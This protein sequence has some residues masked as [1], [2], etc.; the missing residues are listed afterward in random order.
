MSDVCHQ[1][2]LAEFDDAVQLRGAVAR[3]RHAGGYTRIEVYSPFPIVGM[4]EVLDERPSRIPAAVLV[5]ALIG[6]VGTFA[7]EWYA[8]VI[9]YPINVGGR[10]LNSWQAFLPPALEMT[11]LVAALFGVFAMLLGS[12]LPRLNHPLFDNV[13]FE[14]ATDDRFFLLLC[15]DDPQYRRDEARAFLDTLAPVSVT[16]VS[17]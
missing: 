13:A 10:P 4:D 15:A 1:G 16:E 12:R 2:L 5:G 6:G 9:D 11:I 7:L 14:R 17:A 8:A 3:A